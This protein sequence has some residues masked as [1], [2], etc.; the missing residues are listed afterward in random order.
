[1]FLDEQPWGKSG[2][3]FRGS[4]QTWALLIHSAVTTEPRR[5]LQL[6]I[7]PCIRTGGHMAS[8]TATPTTHTVPLCLFSPSNLSFSISASFFKYLSLTTV[9]WKY[10]LLM[11]GVCFVLEVWSRV[12]RRGEFSS[13]YNNN[14]FICSA[15]YIST[16]N[17]K[18]LIHMLMISSYR[19]VAAAALGQADRSEATIFCAISPSD[20]RQQAR[21]VRC[22]AQGNNRQ[23]W[24]GNLTGDPPI[25]RRTPTASVATCF[26]QQQNLLLG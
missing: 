10:F 11:T 15:L 17:L 23:V 18:G 25:A 5:R 3:G 2:S 6:S 21:W 14:N 24:T 26:P 1:M 22:F 4:C 16:W 8:Y 7:C 20:Q 9:R 19:I 12:K 13:D